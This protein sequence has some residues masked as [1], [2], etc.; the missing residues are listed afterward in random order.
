MQSPSERGFWFWAATV[1]AVLSAIVLIATWPVVSGYGSKAVLAQRVERDEA[2]ASLFGDADA[3]QEIGSPQMLIIEDKGALLPGKS[4]SGA[5][6]V[7]EKYLKEK[8]I[9]PLQLKTV[10]YVGGLVRL[11]AG[12]VLAVCLA[13]LAFSRLRKRQFMGGKG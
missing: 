12:A 10:H 9:Y 7:D 1:V 5:Q 4:K 6:M 8:K 11:G 13:L 2:A 3:Y